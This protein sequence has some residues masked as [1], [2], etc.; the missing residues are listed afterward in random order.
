MI[1]GIAVAKILLAMATN[2][3]EMAKS[4]NI[5]RLNSWVISILH[6][7]AVLLIFLLTSSIP[8]NYKGAMDR[9]GR[10]NRQRYILAPAWEYYLHRP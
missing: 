5:E 3:V 9:P 7:L 8:A 2:M 10:Q 6:L 4:A 1:A